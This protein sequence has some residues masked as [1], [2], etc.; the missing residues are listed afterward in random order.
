M[1]LLPLYEAILKFASYTVTPDGYIKTTMGSNKEN[2]V[3]DGRD[4]VLPTR[5]QVS[6]LDKKSK[7]LFHPL[8]EDMTQDESKVCAAYRTNL[9]ALLNLSVV[10]LLLQLSEF[11]ASPAEHK[12]LT[13]EQLQILEAVPEL[14]A[15]S[16]KAIMKTITEAAEKDPYSTF[17]NMYVCRGG[18]FQGKMHGYVAVVTFTFYRDLVAG[19]YESTIKGKHAKAL[20]Q[21][22]EFMFPLIEE[23]DQYSFASEAEFARCFDSVMGAFIRLVTRYKY[24]RNLY[25]NVLPSGDDVL[26]PEFN[27]DWV[28]DYEAKA[29]L[30]GEVRMIQNPTERSIPQAS[31]LRDVPEATGRGYE[32]PAAQQMDRPVVTAEGLDFRAMMQQQRSGGR[33]E[34]EEPR[35]FRDDRDPP[36]RRSEWAD[37]DDDYRRGGREGRRGRG[38]SF[39]ERVARDE[40]EQRN[41]DIE[42][43]DVDTPNGWMPLWEARRRFPEHYARVHPED[44]H[45]DSW[46]RDPF[47]GRRSRY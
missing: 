26:A 13:P 15:I 23:K 18:K 24:L 1:K 44:I 5:E 42:E 22:C 9:A 25:S 35:D 4:L 16:A 43:E 36:R 37:E 19:K 40:R 38:L 20:K 27:M 29:E 30:Y 17:F 12:G 32:R 21:L 7:I 34:R 46:R 6:Y 14:D 11:L 3:V 41:R 31:T 28:P 33:R 2:A 47:A 10:T 45:P 39:R 8:M